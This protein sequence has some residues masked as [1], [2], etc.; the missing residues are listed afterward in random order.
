M[1]A[2]IYEYKLSLI[3]RPQVSLLLELFTDCTW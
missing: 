3:I 2:F 1:I